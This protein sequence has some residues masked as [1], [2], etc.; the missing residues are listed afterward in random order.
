MLT[1]E[2]SVSGCTHRAAGAPGAA[3]LA[4][5]GMGR[6]LGSQVPFRA[7]DGREWSHHISHQASL[8]PSSSGQNSDAGV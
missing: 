8:L 1:G 2:P 5:L 4:Q 6:W 3:L 7:W